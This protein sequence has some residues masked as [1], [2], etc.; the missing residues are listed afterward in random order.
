MH[1]R[2]IWTL[3]ILASVP[4]CAPAQWLHTPLPG[5]PRTPDGKPNL[6]APAPRASHG[7]PDLSGIWMAQSSPIP[8]LISLLPGGINGL[9]EFT[10]SNYFLDILADFKPN[11][12]PLLPPVSASFRERSATVGHDAPITRCLPAGVPAG[13]LV[14]TPFKLIQTPGVIVMLNEI[15]NTF[16]QIFTDGRKQPDD[17]QP[18]WLGYSVGKWQGDWLVVDTAG[19]NDQGWL[20]ASGHTHSE[21]LRVTERFHR[22]DFGHLEVELL[23]DDPKTF[24]KPVTVRFVEELIPDTDLIESFC[25]EDE[26]DLAHLPAK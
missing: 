18:S 21:A 4:L 7:K 26:K 6:T 11:E 15:D 1:N 3:V 12:E 9:G 2:N 5:T 25:S 17:P 24:T 10:P 20:D 22:R 14:P 19:F 16:R 13:D 23:L 8:E